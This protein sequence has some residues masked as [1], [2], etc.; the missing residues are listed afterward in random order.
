M[1]Q[2]GGEKMARGGDVGVGLASPGGGVGQK[3]SQITLSV[4]DEAA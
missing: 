1:E 3:S 2:F 4:R